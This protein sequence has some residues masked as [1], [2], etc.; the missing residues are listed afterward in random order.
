MRGAYLS[1]HNDGAKNF[2]RNF[3]PVEVRNAR[4][5]LEELAVDNKNPEAMTLVGVF[6]EK[7]G[8]KDEAQAM[9]HQAMDLSKMEVDV[10][11]EARKLGLPQIA[12]WNALG[13][14]LKSKGD[15]GSLEQAKEVFKKGALEG[16]DPVSYY[17]LAML[18][19]PN[20][21]DWLQYMQKAAGAGH[22]DAIHAL[23]KFYLSTEPE[24]VAESKDRKLMTML[25]W[26][27]S[28]GKGRTEIL[29][30]EYLTEGVNMGH[31]PSMMTLVSYL[32]RKEDAEK[33]EGAFREQIVGLLEQVRGSPE[34]DK[35]EQWPELVVRA[36]KQLQEM[37]A[38]R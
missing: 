27:F 30:M 3:S 17:E 4:K 31:K 8:F 21:G 29:G 38:R 20:S 16:D 34:G 13:F 28:L 25:K 7:D 9:Y 32:R 24:Q 23:G 5:V 15:A 12:P 37:N 1:A 33:Q 22:L 6:L 14:L 36:R 2:F 19:E 10:G 18:G 35:V 11:V 26:I